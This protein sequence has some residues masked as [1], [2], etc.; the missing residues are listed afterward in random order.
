[1]TASMTTASVAVGISPGWRY[2]NCTDGNCDKYRLEQVCH[3]IPLWRSLI[4]SF[5][6]SLH[7]LRLPPLRC[8]RLLPQWPTHAAS[9]SRYDAPFLDLYG[10]S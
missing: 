3:F 4:R 1:M 9:I 6:N 8:N 10:E 5:N 7:A 2:G